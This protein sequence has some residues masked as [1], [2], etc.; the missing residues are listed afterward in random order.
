MYEDLICSV[1]LTVSGI[2]NSQKGDLLIPGAKL[3]KLPLIYITRK[4]SI[5]RNDYHQ[6]LKNVSEEKSVAFSNR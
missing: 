5:S 1:E 3:I 4:W 6:I 2:E